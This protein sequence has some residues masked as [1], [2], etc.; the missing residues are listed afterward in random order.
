MTRDVHDEVRAKQFTLVNDDGSTAAMLRAEGGGGRLSV[1]GPQGVAEIGASSSGVEVTLADSSGRPRIAAGFGSDGLPS[2]RLIDSER[3]DRVSIY[4]NS[5]DHAIV[6]LAD[7]QGR[8]RTLMVA[9]HEGLPGYLVVN[10]RGERRAALMIRKDGHPSLV[11][12]EPDGSV[13]EQIYD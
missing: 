13:S 5:V 7:P 9:D 8:F 12:F 10:E 4:I 6:G 1:Q 11:F 3:H 2:V